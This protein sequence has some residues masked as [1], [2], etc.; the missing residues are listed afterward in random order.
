MEGIGSTRSDLA[1]I[2]GQIGLANAKDSGKNHCEFFSYPEIS[3]ISEMIDIVKET[4]AVVFQS[5]VF[6]PK[7]IHG[8]AKKAWNGHVVKGFRVSEH[9]S[10]IT[11]LGLKEEKA[12]LIN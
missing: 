11:A 4:E 7:W 1:S 10:R 2:P 9:K 12:L 6:V 5:G 3:S 8:M